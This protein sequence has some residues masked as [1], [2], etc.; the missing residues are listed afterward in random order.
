MDTK[1]V[2]RV[3]LVLLFCPLLGQCRKTH[4]SEAGTQGAARPS[5]SPVEP[6][7]APLE[8][9]APGESVE[10]AAYVV[11]GKT[12]LFEFYSRRC[13]HS[14]EMA[15]VM[16]FLAEQRGDLAIRQV[17]IDRAD[18]EEIDFDSPI[19]EQYEV[20]ATPSFR[21]Y[22][23]D[24]ALIASG[25]AAKDIVRQ[26]YNDARL[27]ERAEQLPDIAERYEKRE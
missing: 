6:D 18:A 16:Q 25:S 24:G 3:V 17:D 21:I 19:A 22:D 23:A 20:H 26:W 15:P 14:A 2:V 13:A 7:L 8:A 9:A 10:L 1:K 12:T 11:P 4:P 5:P 27:G